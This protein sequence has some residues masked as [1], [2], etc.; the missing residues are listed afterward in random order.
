MAITVQSLPA[1]QH[2][3]WLPEVDADTKRRMNEIRQQLAQQHQY[4]LDDRSRRAAQQMNSLTMNQQ[5]GG[6]ADEKDVQD[7]FSKPLEQQF[8]GMIVNKKLLLLES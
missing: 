2:S 1:P 7:F 4:Y 5:F 8:R 3:W 6:L